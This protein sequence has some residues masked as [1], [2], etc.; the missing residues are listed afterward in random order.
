MKFETSSSK[1]ALIIN[2]KGAHVVNPWHIIIDLDQ[3]TITVRKRNKFLIGVDE[4]VIA[5]KYVR[6]I[7]IDEHFVGADIHIKVVGGTAS[8]YCLSKSD[9]EKI[10]EML[11]E[12][13]NSRGGSITIS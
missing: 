12:H 3:E 13:N 5:F 7:T 6:N 1:N 10:K 8:V 2:G 4:Q 9:A 11:L